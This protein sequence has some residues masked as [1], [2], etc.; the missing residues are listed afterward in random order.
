MAFPRLNNIS[1]WLLPPSITLLVASAL[2]ENGAGTGWTVY[3]MDK[4]FLNTIR[5]E[6]LLKYK[7]TRNFIITCKNILSKGTI[8]LNNSY[9][10]EDFSLNNINN[11]SIENHS[12]N[13]INYYSSETEN[14]SL[15]NI[16]SYSIENSS[17]NNIN[18]Y[19]IEN[20]F[21]N[22]I[23]SYSIE[24]SSLFS[25]SNKENKH[26]KFGND[27]EW[28]YQWFVGFTDGNGSFNIDIYT[29]K[30]IWTFKI[31]LKSNNIQVL[32][33]IKNQLGVGSVILDTPLRGAVS[34]IG[35]YG[36]IGNLPLYPPIKNRGI[37]HHTPCPLEV[38]V[39]VGVGVGV[40]VGVGVGG[41]GKVHYIIRDIYSIET[42]IIPLFNKYLPLTSK[43]DDY[44]KFKLCL[45]IWNSEISQDEKIKKI[46]DLKSILISK[47]YIPSNWG[48]NNNPITKPW[49]IGYTE[50]AGSFYLTLKSEKKLIH[51]FSIIHKSDPIVLLGIKEILNI[52]SNV[53]WNYKGFYYLD[54]IN[55][56]DLLG[57]K[58]YYSKTLKGRKSLEYKL[59][60]RSFNYSGKYVKLLKIKKI[61][62]KIL[63]S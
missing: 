34:T 53:K 47:D 60:A 30:I 58:I 1:F 33:Y 19:L 12:L 59:W 42:I 46:K 41:R 62:D 61:I 49:L 45:N 17:L 8:R 28:F 26:G 16:N 40:K 24:N 51:G 39:G 55:Y 25:L 23:N 63:F 10:I 57:I 31:S 29:N 43:E 48:F 20:H 56:T 18:C 7:I 11:Y 4:Q 32:H 5:C 27:K 50:T 54:C 15:N 9:S 38:G 22:N 36:T 2:V 35:T 44:L 3:K 52:K 6:E 21:L 13:N 14:P 37:R